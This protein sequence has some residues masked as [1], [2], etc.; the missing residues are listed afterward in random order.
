L[1]EALHIDASQ[2]T[3][4]LPGQHPDVLGLAMLHPS[5]SACYVVGG[6]VIG[7]IGE[8][9][10]DVLRA[11]G[12]D[13]RVAVG[14]FATAALLALRKRE[15]V[16]VPL[17]KFPYALRDISLT[18][19]RQMTVGEAERLLFE[20]GA[21]LLQRSEL[22]DVYEKDDEK[23]FAFH[24]SFGAPDRTLSSAEM[25]AAFDRIVALAMTHG[26]CLRL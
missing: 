1:L 12:L 25:D 9:H 8:I 21:P 16:F 14:E 6:T 7:V 15:T 4:E 24:L 13:A 17:Q 5:R 26:G 20:A 10:P 22:F 3:L 19:P 11:C 18:F 2:M 23:S